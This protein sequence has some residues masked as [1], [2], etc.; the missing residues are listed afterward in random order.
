MAA[1]VAASAADA[2]TRALNHRVGHQRRAV[3][4]ARDLGGRNIGLPQQ[5]LCT[6]DDCGGGV[7]RGRQ[8]LAGINRVAARMCQDQIRE[9]T[10]Y[11]NANA[12]GRHLRSA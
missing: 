9:S 5:A 4:D 3:D 11:I 2:G 10:A 8:Q 1:G 6:R 7:L 12:Y